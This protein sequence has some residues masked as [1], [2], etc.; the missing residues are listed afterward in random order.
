ML[1]GSCTR[2]DRFLDILEGKSTEKAIATDWEK[3]LE[4]MEIEYSVSDISISTQT[5]TYPRSAE[6][7]QRDVPC[8]TTPPQPATKPVSVKA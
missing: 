4:N 2:V 5:V 7:S 8:P 1:F 6:Y 3:E